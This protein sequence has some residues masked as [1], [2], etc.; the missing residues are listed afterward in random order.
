MVDVNQMMR[1]L[2]KVLRVSYEQLIVII[3]D[4]STAF[5]SNKTLTQI[6][7]KFTPAFQDSRLSSLRMFGLQEIF[8]EIYRLTFALD[9]G[10]H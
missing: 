10:A 3:I 7:F 9:L 2:R 4:L 5:P 6:L 1:F 8:M